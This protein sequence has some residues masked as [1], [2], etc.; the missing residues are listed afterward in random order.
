MNGSP[1]EVSMRDIFW[2]TAINDVS[3]TENAS[4]ENLA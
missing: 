4:T 2:I 1:F 3:R